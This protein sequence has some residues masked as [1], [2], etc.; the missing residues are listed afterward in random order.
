M[1]MTFGVS[2]GLLVSRES[3]ASLLLF[4]TVNVVVLVSPF[5]FPLLYPFKGSWSAK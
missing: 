1:E 5:S 3:N 4:L 2:E